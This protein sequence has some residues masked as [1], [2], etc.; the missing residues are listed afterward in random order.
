MKLARGLRRSGMS[1][2]LTGNQ[3]N[4][5]CDIRAGLGKGWEHEAI[6]TRAWVWWFN[7]VSVW[8]QLYTSIEFESL[9]SFG[10]D[11]DIW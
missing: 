4:L 1:G 6:L 2:T 7:L 11:V 3:S 8:V 10:T 5:S 9:K